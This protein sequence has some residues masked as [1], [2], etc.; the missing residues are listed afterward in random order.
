LNESKKPRSLTATNSPA[1]VTPFRSASHS[2]GV[3]PDF[4]GIALSSL[5]GMFGRPSTSA[6]R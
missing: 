5:D 6:E 1:P 4:P 2:S 3:K